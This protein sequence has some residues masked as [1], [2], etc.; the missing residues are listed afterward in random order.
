MKSNYDF[1]KAERGKF[2]HPDLEVQLPVYLESDVAA[3]FQKFALN[4]DVDIQKLVNAWLRSNISVIQ[5]V[6]S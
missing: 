3:F 4:H 5:S 6:N 2:Y 1:S